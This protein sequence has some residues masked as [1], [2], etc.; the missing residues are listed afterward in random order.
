MASSGSAML[1]VARRSASA[2]LLNRDRRPSRTM[3]PTKAVNPNGRQATATRRTRS[4]APSDRAPPWPPSVAP[5]GTPQPG[6]IPSDRTPAFPALGRHHLFPPGR[7]QH[8]DIL[9]RE[10]RTFQVRLPSLTKPHPSG[11]TSRPSRISHLPPD[12]ISAAMIRQASSA[13]SS[14]S[15]N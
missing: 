4:A 11:R 8:Y 12:F 13:S 5:L 15:S 10:F 3:P 14:S 1:K 9:F 2:S 7:W 6:R